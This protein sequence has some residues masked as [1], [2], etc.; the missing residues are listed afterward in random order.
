MP[1][2]PGDEPPYTQWTVPTRGGSEAFLYR[3]TSRAPV[4]GV[5]VTVTHRGHLIPRPELIKTRAGDGRLNAVR[6]LPREGW[7]YPVTITLWTDD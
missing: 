6:I 5:R 7:L 2:F 3:F 4:T 1:E